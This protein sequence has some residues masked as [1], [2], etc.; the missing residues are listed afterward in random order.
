VFA[1]H[2]GPPFSGVLRKGISGA[3]M[4]TMASI[5]KAGAD[6]SHTRG[7]ERKPPHDAARYTL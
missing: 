2:F 5:M 6:V 7:F 4:P 3:E 1:A